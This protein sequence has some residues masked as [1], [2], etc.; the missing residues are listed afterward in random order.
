MHLCFFI[1]Q[2][3][4]RRLSG[5]F[6]HNS[7]ATSFGVL[8]IAWLSSGSDRVNVGWDS[9][10]HA[11]GLEGINLPPCGVSV[12]LSLLKSSAAFQSP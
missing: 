9:C 6:I 7:K 11:S 3:P 1:P 2:V 10:S 12:V 8:Y 4:Y 5:I